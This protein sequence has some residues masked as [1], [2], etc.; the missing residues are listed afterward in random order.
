MIGLLH[1]EILQAKEV[2]SA[3]QYS[4]QLYKD[5]FQRLEQALYFETLMSGW[6]AFRNYI[7]TEA[8]LALKWC[9]E[10]M[11][12]DE[13]LIDE[14][15]LMGLVADLEDLKKKLSGKELPTEVCVFVMHQIEILERAI[16]DYRIIGM[17]AFAD[18]QD[19]AIMD[20]VQNNEI[21]KSDPKN[22]ALI[23]LGTIWQKVRRYINSFGK[24]ARFLKEA[25][26][27]YDIGAHLLN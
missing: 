5:A 13:Q 1:N 18:A 8:L 14:K 24:I 9:V 27:V 10:T 16:R 19:V 6:G 15:D 26:D 12:K 4:P 17:K 22:E 25:K 23:K 2:M 7:T 11:P 21:V 20:I 3:T